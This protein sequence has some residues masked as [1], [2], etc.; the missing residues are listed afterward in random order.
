MLHEVR[1]EYDIAPRAVYGRQYVEVLRWRASH[2]SDRRTLRTN[3][4]VAKSP[5][6]LSE[7]MDNVR[8]VHERGG[9]GCAIVFFD[10]DVC[11]CTAYRAR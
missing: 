5:I 8:G 10:S 7:D 1:R 6:V 4:V 3:D 11:H 2:S 9:N